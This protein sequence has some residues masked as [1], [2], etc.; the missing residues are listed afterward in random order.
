MENVPTAKE[1]AQV[2]PDVQDLEFVAA[3]GFKAVFRGKVVGKVEAIKIAY[4]PP[5]ATEDSSR[6]EIALRVKRIGS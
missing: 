1:V 5:A 2:R 4:I 6:E 3:G